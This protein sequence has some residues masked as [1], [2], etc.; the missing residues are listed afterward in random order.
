M[1]FYPNPSTFKQQ[2]LDLKE[3]ESIVASQLAG[4]F[5]LPRNKKKKLV[6]IAGG[7]GIT[8]FHSM[9][10]NLIN[11]KEKRDIIQFY[12]NKLESEEAYKDTFAQA[13]N[14][15]N[16]KTVYAVTD[17]SDPMYTGR[18]N[19]D[20]IK[21]EVPDYKERYYYLSGPH[22]LVTAFEVTLKNLG[23]KRSHIKTDFF[24][25]FV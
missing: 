22:N 23:I 13:H 25:G 10:K 9:I 14:D 1:K 15:L 24:P 6:F 18:I 17:K 8:P 16:I 5:V 20:L 2:L 19:E 7:I 3:G 11:T 4:D 21:R 12:S